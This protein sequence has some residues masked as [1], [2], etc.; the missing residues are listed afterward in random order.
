MPEPVNATQ[1]VALDAIWDFLLSG[2]RWPTYQELDQ[3]LYRSYDLDAAVL[4]PELPHGLLYGVA[5]GSARSIGATTSIGLTAAGVH[6]TGR[7]QRELD[8]FITVVRH[9]VTVQRDYD[10]PA[11]QPHLQPGLTSADVATLLELDLPDAAA[12]LKRL[13]F[14]LEAEQWGWTNFG[15]LGTDAWEVRV[16]REVRRFRHVRDVATYWDLRPKYWVTDEFFPGAR[17]AAADNAANQYGGYVDSVDVLVIA[18]LPEE[19]EAAKAAGRASAPAGSGVLRWDERDVDGVPFVWG[20]YRVD[21]QIRFTVALARPTQMGGRAT[22]PFAAS[23]V[24]RLRPVTPP[25]RRWATSWSV[26]PSTSGTRASIRQ[27]GSRAITDNSDWNPP[28]FA[29]HRTSTPTVCPA[30]ATPPKT[31]R[32]S[33]SSNSFTAA[34]N[35]AATPHAPPTFRMTPGS[36]A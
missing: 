18:A 17:D 2:G 30:T 15:G 24:D 5:A 8:L 19:F 32:C 1:K 20:E 25:T 26:S 21:G 27:P 36:P 23:L 12:L 3:V 33:G 28:G 34:S 29:S 10:P 22:G 31:R 4:L 16:G 7:G 13:S 14:I 11:D 9:A 35:H 6:A